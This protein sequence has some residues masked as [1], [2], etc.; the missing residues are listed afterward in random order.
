MIM[1]KIKKL[2]YVKLINLGAHLYR[3]KSYALA[4]FIWSVSIT[5]GHSSK[6]NIM[7]YLSILNNKELKKALPKIYF[8][9]VDDDIAVAQ[10][11]TLTKKR[12]LTDFYRR[13]KLSRVGNQNHLSALINKISLS[14]LDIKVE[15]YSEILDA[16]Q[17]N[18]DL[19]KLIYCVANNVS[20][21][22]DVS[23]ISESNLIMIIKY[24]NENEIALSEELVSRLVASFMKL[25]FKSAY[26]VAV[27]LS[28]V[29]LM[30]TVAWGTLLDIYP[31]DT[32]VI[33]NYINS[34]YKNP[35]N[36]I[37]VA[38][39]RLVELMSND[40]RDNS[41]YV[42]NQIL[43]GNLHNIIP[44]EIEINK[45]TY[46]K[47]IDSI[48]KTN[49][50][51][52]CNRYIDNYLE[53]YGED[54]EISTLR[55]KI[56]LQNGNYQLA[57][58]QAEDI[59]DCYYKALSYLKTKDVK[60]AIKLIDKIEPSSKNYSEAQVMRGDI[61]FYEFTNYENA[62]RYYQESNDFKVLDYQSNIRMLYC[63]MQ[64]NEMLSRQ[65]IESIKP[66]E[67]ELMKF[68]SMVKKNVKFALSRFNKNYYSSNVMPISVSQKS[69]GSNFFDLI[70]C[71]SK[72]R[73]SGPLVSIIMTTFNCI[74]TIDLA[75]KSIIDQSYKNIEI[76]IV[77]DCSSDG[78]FEYLQ[79]NYN[80]VKIF[81][82][83][84]TPELM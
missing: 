42:Y 82:N 64:L 62:L 22:L 69:N 63:K 61:E 68:S 81:Q 12:R 75:I 23:Y 74:E 49:N 67:L 65:D 13:I 43:S 20:I 55:F 80:G 66:Y 48:R 2:L 36:D 33:K 27:Y 15:L 29:N 77:D 47:V 79:N 8:N 41:R 46:L 44:L 38:Y 39:K 54:N 5:S 30:H 72:K 9:L 84:K 32:R 53:S 40:I 83:K 50:I 52:L 45:T 4:R 17:I 37:G 14:D 59:G 60:G 57:K 26:C 24:C 56:S 3:N 6:K 7:R 35:N 76:I 78:T 21:E 18:S 1:K 73:H 31:D 70:Y 28:K 19:E 58:E 11:L 71:V 25:S 51:N 16:Q 10:L 34:H